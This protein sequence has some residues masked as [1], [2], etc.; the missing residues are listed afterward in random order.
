MTHPQWRVSTCNNCSNK[1]FYTNSHRSATHDQ[2]TPPVA[3]NRTGPP[4]RL[5]DSKLRTREYLTE[6]EVERLMN[7]A[8]KNRWGHRDA[9][10]ILTAYRHGLCVPELVDLRWEPNRVRL[11]YTS[12]DQL[13]SIMETFRRAAP[14]LASGRQYQNLQ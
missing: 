13:K 4:K 10:M 2:T 8:R 11:G 1:G 5:P 7:A 3:V 14:S 6:A 9:T 12:R